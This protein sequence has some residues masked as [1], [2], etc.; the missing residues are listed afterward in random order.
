MKISEEGMFSVAELGEGILKVLAAGGTIGL[1]LIAPNVVMTLDKPLRRY[2]DGLDYQ[3]RD[4]QLKRA[5]YYVKRQGWIVADR[6]GYEFGLKVTKLGRQRLYE[7][8]L[9][10]LEI[11]TP[12]QWDKK[13]RLVFY[14]IPEA[15][16]RGRNHL[17][18]QLKDLGFYPL[19]RS[20]FVHP[21]PCR[22]E[23]E[24]VA[25]AHGVERYITYIEADTIDPHPKL[26]KK[27]S[28]LN[29]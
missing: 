28:G 22:Q 7:V 24:T 19:Q 25:T 9:D 1:V 20:V 29:L 6:D 17:V 10:D 5:L 8:E 4:R 15:H 13:W 11:A 26:I 16:R 14:D 27:F 23:V 12:D 3:T 2:L 21:F 18:R